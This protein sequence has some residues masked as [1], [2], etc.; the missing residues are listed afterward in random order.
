[1]NARLVSALVLGGAMAACARPAVPPP[2]PDYGRAIDAPCN[3][4]NDVLAGPTRSMRVADAEVLVPSAWTASY[5]NMNDLRLTR[6]S[7]TLRIWKGVDAVFPPMLPANATECQ[8]ERGDTVIVIRTEMAPDRTF[9]VDARW[10]PLIDG[11]HFF[12]QLRT[13]V[14]SQLGDVRGII[15]STKFPIDSTPETKR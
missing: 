8:I 13:R 3:P 12:M 4:S 6:S 7:A 5:A 1:M 11:Q 15:V 14:V 9:R 10:S 2:S